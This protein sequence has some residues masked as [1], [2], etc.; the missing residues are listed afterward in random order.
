MTVV[1]PVTAR[2]ARNSLAC[3][4]DLL[5]ELPTHSFSLLNNVHEHPR[6]GGDAARKWQQPL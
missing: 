1:Y 6:L 5:R 2:P 3:L 4:Y